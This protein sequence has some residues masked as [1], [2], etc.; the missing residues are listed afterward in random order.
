MKLDD[1]RDELRASN[2]KAAKSVTIP[3]A[4]L[5]TLGLRRARSATQHLAAYLWVELALNLLAVVLLGA[6]AVSHTAP[7]FLAPALVLEVAALSHVLFSARQLVA[8]GRLDFA[9]PV[10]AIQRE[11]ET[12]RIGR[13]GMTKWTLLLSP[14]L[15]IPLLVVTLE[16]FFRVNTYAVFDRTW[17]LTNVLFGVA[18]VP[19]MLAVSRRLADRFEGSPTLRRIVRDIA[20]RNLSAAQDF[21]DE[22][23]RLET[24]ERGSA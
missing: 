24:G 17:L 10:V 7:R 20:G 2:A 11:L 8:L 4:K 1:L 14:L 21:L 6:F 18:F 5:R 9:A 23:R 3:A 12:L 19:A 22:I 13:I 15:W 16:G